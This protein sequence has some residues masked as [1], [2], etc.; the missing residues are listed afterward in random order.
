M[1][2]QIL[3]RLKTI[4]KSKKGFSVAVLA[5]GILSTTLI[6]QNAYTFVEKPR[7]RA[8]LCSTDYGVLN[9]NCG[10]IM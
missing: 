2:N 9:V 6:P 1:N 7:S 8:A 10:D 4:S 5:T 3:N